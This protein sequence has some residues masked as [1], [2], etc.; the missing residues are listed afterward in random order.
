MSLHALVNF[1]LPNDR[2]PA[3]T[4]VEL[5]AQ[6]H[7]VARPKEQVE[8][9]IHDLRHEL[10][11]STSSV[12][13]QLEERSFAVLRNASAHLSD[14]ST[15]SGSDAY[16]AEQCALVKHLTGAS[17]VIGWN[18]VMRRADEKDLKMIPRQ[19]APERGAPPSSHIQPPASSA[20]ID[21]DRAFGGKLVGM[22]A[23]G[24]DLSK[25]TRMQIINVWR[26]LAVVTNSPL[27]VVDSRTVDVSQLSTQ[28]SIFG[29]GLDLHHSPSQRWHYIQHQ[30][31]DEV[32][33]LRC[34][35]SHG[36]NACAHAAV[37]IVDE[38]SFGDGPKVPRS[39]VEV[40]L[41]VLHE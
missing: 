34:W 26:P 39:S 10:D 6:T 14:L 23:E 21:Q 30:R 3:D 11:T 20:H 7:K 35:D 15:P 8:V 38:P 29:Y 17:R 40:R 37:D 22:A 5:F 33:I 16:L 28:A 24:D 1:A 31:E 9:P 32:L 19:Q 13:S 36:R 18:S 25:Y 27:G 12:A 4:N 41:V 2:L